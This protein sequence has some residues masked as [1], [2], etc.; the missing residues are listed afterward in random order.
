MFIVCHVSFYYFIVFIQ[1]IPRDYLFTSIV[2]SLFISH[3]RIIMFGNWY[4]VLLE[5][6]SDSVKSVVLR[7]TVWTAESGMLKLESDGAS[8][9]IWKTILSHTNRH[10]LSKTNI[11]LFFF[12]FI[13]QFSRCS[14]NY[15]R[16]W[17]IRR[18]TTSLKYQP[19]VFNLQK[20][21]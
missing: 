11:C 21:F 20:T 2:F 4:Q 9:C 1:H 18:I 8:Y 19:S 16:H 13:W 7:R 15:Y 3:L 6:N 17:N 5:E 12:D 14:L 10:D